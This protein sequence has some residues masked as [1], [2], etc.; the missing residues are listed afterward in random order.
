MVKIRKN[1]ICFGLKDL[2]PEYEIVPMK[3]TDDKLIAKSIIF[4]E[5]ISVDEIIK[6]FYGENSQYC[7]E[8]DEYK[9]DLLK[10]LQKIV[11][12]LIH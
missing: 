6:T 4:I 11:I 5:E 3:L 2:E 9:K 10:G 7:N 12:I 8:N 1:L